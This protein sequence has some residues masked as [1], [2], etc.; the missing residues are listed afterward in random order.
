MPAPAGKL[1]LPA[2]ESAPGS[3]NHCD[4]VWRWTVQKVRIDPICTAE[5]WLTDDV[6]VSQTRAPA[7]APG[8]RLLAS[9]PTGPPTPNRVPTRADEALASAIPCVEIESAHRSLDSTNATMAKPA[10]LPALGKAATKAAPHP[11]V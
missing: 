2:P 3:G 4:A 1:A 6:S 11:A 7:T 9:K 5:A 8:G 10:E